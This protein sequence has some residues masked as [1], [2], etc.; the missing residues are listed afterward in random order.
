MSPRSLTP[1]PLCHRLRAGETVTGLFCELPCPEAV[2]IAGLAGWD[3]VIID[4][5]HAPITAHL[6]P[7]MVR[8]AGSAGIPS[9]VRVASSDAA[10]IQHALD[11]GAS[12][13]QIPQIA[14]AAAA[15]AAV[16]A[17][18]FHPIGQRGFNPFVRAADFSAMHVP[19]FL[20]AGN[21]DVT[22]VLQIES[23]AGLE[24]VDAVLELAGIDVLFVGPYD[25]SQSLGIPGEVSHPRVL[26]A[27]E[28]IV[29]A[30]EARGV[31]VGVFANSAEVAARWLDTGIRYLCYTVDSVL[32]LD[33]MRRAILSISARRS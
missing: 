16:S 28:R 4:G 20:E 2:E 29:K 7:A 32:L 21:R 1:A 27:A 30:A 15:R 25:L 24:A 10:G 17:S 26:A 6:L 19:Q 12:G 9:I 18:R 14:S 11:A 3:F 13:V 31:A 8:A 5:E 33:A 23:A 22:L